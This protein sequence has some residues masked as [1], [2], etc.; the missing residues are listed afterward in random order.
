MSKY[1]LVR[2]ED[3][4]ALA[5]SCVL[6]ES[7]GVGADTETYGTGRTDRAFALQLATERHVWY[8]NFHDYSTNWHEPSQRSG[9]P[10]L[11]RRRTF[12]ALSPLLRRK[13]L[14]W[15]IH[16][17]KFDLRRFA[18][19]DAEVSGGVHCTQSIERFIYN[20]HMRYSLAACL[21]RRGLS[22]DDAVAKYIAE[23]SLHTG[24]AV[25]G[26]KH[27]E[28]VPF[29]LMFEYGCSDAERCRLLGIDQRKQLEQHAFYHNDLE[30]QKVAFGMEQ[31][32]MKVRTEYAQQGLVYE[33]QKQ[34]ESAI[35]LSRLAGEPFRS[36]P[37]WLSGIFD[38]Y[39]VPYRR[40]PKTGKP[41][42]DKHALDDI[43]HPIAGLVREYR[44]HEKYAS[45]YYEVYASNEVIHAEI[46]LGGTDTGRFSYADPN[47]QNVPKEEV[48]D[49]VK[50]PAKYAKYMSIPY[51]V[52]GCF[53]PRTLDHFFGMVDYDQQEFRLMLDYAG[54]FDL[55]R[56][57]N[58][59]GED[60][61]QATADLV[62]VSR[63]EAKTINFG[64]LYGMGVEKLAKA[65]GISVRDA[66]MLKATYFAKLPRVQKLIAAIIEKAER[67][68]YVTTWTGR[69]LYVPK[70]WRD[71]HTGA[72]VRFEYVMPN[73]LIQGGCGDIAR[74]AMP[75]VDDL[76]RKETSQS[77]M[78]LQVHDEL[79]FEIH[80]TEA[81]ILK[82]IVGI[83]E[84]TY[85]PFNGM[86]MTCG[87]DHSWVSWSKLDVVKGYPCL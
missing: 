39:E 20:Q 77:S 79:L 8:F 3:D 33:R 24:G 65:L 31:I 35:E 16:N 62:G 81:D 64:L 18:L 82:R 34:Q 78:L 63:K 15:F 76:I 38:R 54:E 75:V 44:R 55:I 72:L 28:Q 1:R 70:P 19:E 21:E 17:A 47:L 42:F 61:H 41:V 13:D 48:P 40:N 85:R 6:E 43:D 23:H 29:D 14:V 49:P 50:E 27:F 9:V 2:T 83:M 26:K 67:Q 71:P 69:K 11:D 87:V 86:K 84:N 66:K 80:R 4:V 68:G 51:Q 30:L 56:R 59:H 37:N 25:N 12:A 22:K 46:K 36:G 53:A 73:H 32:G 57:I 10:I 58:D 52:R 7:S 5:V 74:L 45:T 60:V